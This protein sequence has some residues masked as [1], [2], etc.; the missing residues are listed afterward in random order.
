MNCLESYFKSET[1]K[2]VSDVYPFIKDNEKFVDIIADSHEPY[3]RQWCLT[4][5]AY[6]EETE[7]LK[8]L[9][10]YIKSLLIYDVAVTQNNSSS[11]LKL[12]E[13]FLER[14]RKFLSKFIE[15]SD[16]NDERL[17]SIITIASRLTIFNTSTSV[18]NFKSAVTLF[19]D[20][21]LSQ[22]FSISYREF[23][24]NRTNV[25]KIKFYLN[26]CEQDDVDRIYDSLY[27]I[28][29]AYGKYRYCKSQ[30]Q[31]ANRFQE[32]MI[33]AVENERDGSSL[34]I[35]YQ[36][37]EL[38]KSYYEKPEKR[39]YGTIDDLKDFLSEKSEFVGIS[40]NSD[41]LEDG[42][43]IT[44]YD[45][46]QYDHNSAIEGYLLTDTK[47]DESVL[48]SIMD[49]NIIK[50]F[51][52]IMD[53]TGY[54]PP[55]SI[56][57]DAESGIHLSEE[58]RIIKEEIVR[59][60]R[61]IDVYAVKEIY[62][63]TSIVSKY[64]MRNKIK[65]DFRQISECKGHYKFDSINV[66]IPMVFRGNTRKQLIKIISDNKKEFDHVVLDEITSKSIYRKSKLSLNYFELS[67]VTLTSQNE[68][69]YIFDI[70]KGIR[71]ALEE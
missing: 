65:V 40:L 11:Y 13:L 66:T 35:Y 67:N 6:S 25:F 8:L 14:R 33:N 54:K 19:S 63:Q 10:I 24:G 71:D 26:Q 36:I 62:D 49:K 31:I 56:T 44:L 3:S 48:Y 57:K 5:L 43:F 51:R 28:F 21:E 23:V 22:N 15:T 38:A 1:I 59:K 41:Y 68:L 58:K 60:R 29:V 34:S 53:G 16:M 52:K 46:M 7:N 9:T 50:Y 55:L 18:E 69:V 32:F 39:F 64:A 45:H 4:L 12:E 17:H 2:L 42:Y 47:I 20:M 37:D 70:K 30:N 61:A 27:E